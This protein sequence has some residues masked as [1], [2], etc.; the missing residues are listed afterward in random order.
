MSLWAVVERGTDPDGFLL[1]RH[2]STISVTIY[3]VSFGEEPELGEGG[4][5]IAAAGGAEFPLAEETVV[6]PA[7]VAAPAAS[8]ASADACGAAVSAG[9]FKFRTAAAMLSPSGSSDPTADSPAEA[10]VGP[11]RPVADAADDR[12]ADAAGLVTASVEDSRAGKSSTARS[13]GNATALYS[14]PRALI[15]MKST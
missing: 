14:R 4:A 15:P 9:P 1:A 10:V 11:V 2:R 5:E 6:R 12:A 13:G 3:D 8:A 7:K